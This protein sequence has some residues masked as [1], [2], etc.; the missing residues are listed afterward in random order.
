MRTIIDLGDDRMKKLDQI[1]AVKK[2]SRAEALRQAAD[3]YIAREG[4]PEAYTLHAG[5]GIW[6]SNTA[7]ADGLDYQEKIRTEWERE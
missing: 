4:L 5:L 7:F 2:I 1:C 3:N 6:K